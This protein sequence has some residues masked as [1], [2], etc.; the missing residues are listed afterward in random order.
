M[1]KILIFLIIIE[2]ALIF[3]AKAQKISSMTSVSSLTGTELI[4]TVQSGTNKKFTPLQMRTFI[5]NDPD[6]VPVFGYVVRVKDS[7]SKIGYSYTTRYDFKTEPSL[8]D[9]IKAF[10]L[11]GAGIKALPLSVSNALIAG[12]GLNDGTVEMA[13]MYVSDTISATGIK[14]IVTLPGAYTGDNTNGVSLYKCNLAGLTSAKVAESA[15]TSTA[16]TT[17]GVIA[18]P[19]TSPYVMLPG[20]YYATLLW[21]NSAVTTAPQIGYSAN[22]SQHWSDW[23]ANGGSTGF[24]IAGRVTSQS[25][26]PASILNTAVTRDNAVFFLTIY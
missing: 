4:P 19:F 1:K 26:F 20:F 25:T 6:S 14:F 11:L 22:I 17:A 12:D 8:P 9:E 16:Y 3:N 24:K 23:I 21:N 15:N 10:N 18:I 13:L 5:K 2:L 7:V